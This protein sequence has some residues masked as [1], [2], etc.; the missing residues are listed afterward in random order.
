MGTETRSEAYEE[1]WNA[2]KRYER[3]YWLFFAGLIPAF[4]IGSGLASLV[5][6]DVPIFILLGADV[7]GLG[8]YGWQPMAFPCPRCGQ[9]FFRR[10]WF[11]NRFTGRCLHCG[12]RKWTTGEG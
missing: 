6:S 2:L 5:K 11:H 12:L 7:V 4:L 1:H 9:D 10:R 8:R 3:G